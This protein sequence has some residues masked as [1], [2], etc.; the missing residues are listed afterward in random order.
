MGL[1][2]VYLEIFICW[3]I[4]IQQVL[5][6]NDNNNNNSNKA[7]IEQRTFIDDYDEFYT[8]TWVIHLPGGTKKVEELVQGNNL[9]FLGAVGSLDDLYMIRHNA[10]T[11]FYDNIDRV[12][13]RTRRNTDFVEKTL[14]SHD[15]Q[16]FQQQKILH[17]EKR[18]YFKDPLYSQQWYLENQGMYNIT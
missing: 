14:G 2:L 17:R 3:F 10:D 4:A 18:G 12:T 7:M 1:P 5:A 6:Y 9:T 8:N 11:D 15:V 16:F 13:R